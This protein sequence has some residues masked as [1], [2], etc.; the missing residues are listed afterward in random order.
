MHISFLCLHLFETQKRRVL[1]LTFTDWEAFAALP[2]DTAVRPAQGRRPIRL[3][4]PSEGAGRSHATRSAAGA[5]WRLA[6]A[7][8]AR[9]GPPRG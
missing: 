9:L 4:A 3:A 7:S 6:V 8:G 5:A 2:V 1:F